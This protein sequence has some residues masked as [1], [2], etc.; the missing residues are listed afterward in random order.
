VV[1]F[2]AGFFHE[3]SPR[4]PIERAA[5]VGVE[6]AW[7][8]STQAKWDELAVAFEAMLTD[9]L[10]HAGVAFAS[11]AFSGR[12]RERKRFDRV[13]ARP[14]RAADVAIVHLTI[15]GRV[16]SAVVLARR[17]R[18]G[19][20]TEADQRVLARL[21]PVLSVSD[22]LL[23]SRGES[24]V[25]RATKLSCVDGRLTPRQ[26]QIMEHVALGHSNEEIAGALSISSHTVR[27]LLV[28]VRA[29]LGAANRAE[30][31]HRAAF[32]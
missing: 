3:L 26:R 30:A 4:S 2:D 8:T 13:I 11:R 12:P 18:S 21:V 15:R 5:T 6:P 28:A 14:L 16:V 29:R 23:Q 9:G 1:H 17:L 22:A 27:N 20:F 25:G 24:R 19:Y 10:E 31:V 32:E 7:L